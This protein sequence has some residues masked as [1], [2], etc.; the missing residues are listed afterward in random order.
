MSIMAGLCDYYNNSQ[1]QDHF[2]VH[3]EETVPN[4]W[5]MLGYILKCLYFVVS[6]TFLMVD[7]SK[8]SLLKKVPQY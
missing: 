5:G 8:S 3:W 1:M 4:E 6:F 2:W 7:K